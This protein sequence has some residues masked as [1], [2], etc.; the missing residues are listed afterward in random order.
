MRLFLIASFLFLCFGGTASATDYPTYAD[1]FQ[2]GI[3]SHKGG[4]WYNAAGAAHSRHKEYFTEGGGY[5]RSACGY[6]CG[7]TYSYAAP[8]QY[9]RWIYTAVS[10]PAAYVPPAAPAV[11]AY[12]PG[13]KEKVIDYARVRDDQQAYLDALAALGIKGQSFGFQ[14]TN[15][16]NYGGYAAPAVVS[17]QTVYGHSFA[18]LQTAYGPSLDT[19]YQS[20]SRLTQSAQQLG[21]Q[22]T[23]DFTALVGQAGANQA[24]IAEILARA[25]AAAT[26]LQATAPQAS[27]TTITTGQA[28]GVGVQQATGQGAGGAAPPVMPQAR[29]GNGDPQAN[30][31]PAAGSGDFLKTVG[32]PLCGS[33]HGAGASNQNAFDIT[34]YPR[35][36]IQQKARVWD[37]LTT[38]DE[39]KAMPRAKGGGAGQPVTAAQL[40]EFYVN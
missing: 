17:G 36:S 20:A 14:Q 4:L 39:S 2:E 32:L 35:M 37:R 21:G 26:A 12:T 24:R 9:F 23:T 13:W 5:V 8:Q 38:A 6:G 25:Q 27:T 1:G 15:S 40:H 16:H 11:P 34:A 28:T 19:L 3:Y 18:Q 10:V 30:A 31:A 7:Y 33:C 29:D 22:A